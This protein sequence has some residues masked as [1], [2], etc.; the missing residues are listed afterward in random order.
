M[1]GRIVY[2]R[3]TWMRKGRRSDGG[4]SKSSSMW[5]LNMPCTR[6]TRDL[7]MRLA[8][9]EQFSVPPTEEKT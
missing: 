3:A 4:A 7:K 8:Q 9:P 5:Q 2:G 6:G 1:H